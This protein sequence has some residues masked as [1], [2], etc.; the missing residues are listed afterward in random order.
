MLGEFP[1]IS[2]LIKLR[3]EEGSE[4]AVIITIST[5]EAGLKDVLDEWIEKYGYGKL[6]PEIYDMD[7]YEVEAYLRKLMKKLEG[8]Q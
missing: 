3:G 2:K 7:P 1:E 8:G 6:P 5:A 4:I